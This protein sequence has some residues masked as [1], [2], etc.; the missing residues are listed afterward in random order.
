MRKGEGERDAG[1]EERGE[2]E[3]EEGRGIGREH[4]RGRKGEGERDREKARRSK[5]GKVVNDHW[6][7]N[8]C[9]CR[10]VARLHKGLQDT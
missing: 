5:D 10:L 6:S 8:P 2:M 1:R 7:C 4:G 3:R 9:F